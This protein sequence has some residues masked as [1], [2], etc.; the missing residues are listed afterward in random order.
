M[1]INEQKYYK[2]GL[3]LN[4]VTIELKNT[5]LLLLEGYDAF[6][7]CGALDTKVYQNREV[8][9]GK[10]VGVKTLEDLYNA[11]IADSSNYAKSL[12]I[13]PGMYVYEAFQQISQKK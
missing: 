3:D 1:R 2:D 4:A 6:F 8:L 13:V 9:C 7:M 5:T 12:G 10:A 11:P